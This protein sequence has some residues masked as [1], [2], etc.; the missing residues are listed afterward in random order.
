[1]DLYNRFGDKVKN[2]DVTKNTTIKKMKDNNLLLIDKIDYDHHKDWLNVFGEKRKTYG[3]S[4]ALQKDIKHIPGHIYIIRNIKT[5]MIYIGQTEDVIT[6]KTAH[7]SDLNNFTHISTD[8]QMDY[9]LYGSKSFTFGIVEFDVTPDKLLEREKHW[10]KYFQSEFPT[11]YNMPY[12]EKKDY[13]QRISK[14]FVE[15]LLEVKKQ[16]K[17]SLK[18]KDVSKSFLEKLTSF[19]KWVND[20]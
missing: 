15:E 19:Y 2:K 6:R 7:L 11:G 5:G 9:I 20:D 18:G 3:W 16:S 4:Y 13:H 10:I 1:M 12:V 14:K 8:M 17:L